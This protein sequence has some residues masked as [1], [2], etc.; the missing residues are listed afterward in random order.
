MDDPFSGWA[1]LELMGHRR[2]GGKVSEVE[3]YGVKMCRIDIPDAKDPDKTY[4]TQLYGGGSIYCQTMVTKEMACA[5]AARSQPDPVQPWEL[6]QLPPAE[7]QGVRGAASSAWRFSKDGPCPECGD[8][9][10][11]G[12]GSED[13]GPRCPDCGELS[14]HCSCNNDP[15]SSGPIGPLP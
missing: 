15:C 4:M 3:R 7:N 14:R 8:P 2:L 1:I 11:Y 9:K 5:I 6:P 10:C 13:D 12:C